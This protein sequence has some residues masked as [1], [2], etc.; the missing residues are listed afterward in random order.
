M[1]KQHA[2]FTKIQRVCQMKTLPLQIEIKRTPA[3][4]GHAFLFVTFAVLKS[5]SMPCHFP[6]SPSVSLFSA[7][8]R[9]NAHM[10]LCL[11]HPLRIDLG[12]GD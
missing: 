2:W 5:S 6:Q 12:F 4:S 1:L 9:V 3:V 7:L 8:S 11:T 10:F